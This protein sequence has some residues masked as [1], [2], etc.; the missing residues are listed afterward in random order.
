MKIINIQQK[1]FG[2][3]IRGGD[4]LGVCNLLDHIRFLENNPYIKIY[5]P[6]ESIED[7][8]SVKKLREILK[9]HT[10]YFSETPGET[11]LTW[12][13][14]NIFDFRDISGDN[15]VIKNTAEQKKKIVVCPVFDAPYNVYRNWPGPTMQSI[16]GKFNEEQY[17]DYEKV[18]CI[19][20]NESPFH[21]D[22]N[23]LL[24]I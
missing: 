2:G 1:D 24:S 18:I 9:E 22:E 4:I 11:S 20:D 14:V 13:K 21:G 6:D 10:D 17:Q 12:R 15:V 16:I 19:A 7:R 23:A 3:R 8:S 5:L